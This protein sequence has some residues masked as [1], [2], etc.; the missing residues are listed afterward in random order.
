[1][2][3]INYIYQNSNNNDVHTSVF[4]WCCF[5][6]FAKGNTFRINKHADNLR[7][8]YEADRAEI[9]KTLNNG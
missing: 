4:M 3:I 9:D 2:L 1:M 8:R 5:Y 7:D 6:E